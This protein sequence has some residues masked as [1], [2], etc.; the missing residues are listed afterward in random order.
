MGNSEKIVEDKHPEKIKIMM[1]DDDPSFFELLSHNIKELYPASEIQFFEDPVD[2][3]NFY[4]DN[5]HDIDI[6][7]LDM[8]MPKMNGLELSWEIKKINKNERIILMTGYSLETMIAEKGAEAVEFFL[9]KNE[10]DPSLKNFP[11]LLD[12]YVRKI[13]W[14]KESQINYQKSQEELHNKTRLL[15]LLQD[16]IINAD[17]A[18]TVEEAMQ[19]CLDNICSYSGWPVGHLYLSDFEGRLLPTKIWHLDSPEQF[20]TFRTITEN[21][22]FDSGVGLPGQVLAGRKPTWIKDVTKDSNFP[23]AKLAKDINVKAGFAFPISEGK[24]VVAVLEFFSNKIEEPDKHLLET[25]SVFSTQLGRM[26]ERKKAEKELNK[27]ASEM[28]QLAE[29]RSKQLVHADRMATLGTL[30][31][32]I[33]HEVNNPVGFVS[34]NLQIFE[35]LWNKGIKACLEKANREN[36]D[37]NL[38][39]ALDEMPKMVKV[40][41]EGTKRITNIVQ[42]LGKFSRITRPVFETSDICE[43]IET[44]VKFCRLDLFMKHE[45]KI[46]LDLPNNI[47]NIKVSR[48]EMEQVLI[49]IITNSG[50]AMKGIAGGKE[51]ILKIAASHVSNNIIIEINDNG[52][53]MDEKTLDKI[54]NPFFTT[55]DVGKG[56]GLGLSICRGIVEQ[57]RGT[58]TARSTLGEETT[59][60]IILPIDPQKKERRTKDQKIIGGMRDDDK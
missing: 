51:L 60:T 27:Y 30:S 5:Y 4:R 39:F 10:I 57:H 16:V 6:I 44:A 12:F 26:T 40:M 56:T 15:Q 55:K 28:E 24:K 53:G 8:V 34:V 20:K 45:V 35:K 42:S 41:K 54:F 17:E 25:M 36:E 14:I 38:S 31:A 46:K 7:I 3:L 21:T 23:R 48:Q 49:N 13:L 33:A 19:V 37:K 58:I 43:I 29:E 47:P 50:H 9:S 59:F 2:A 22:P 11:I 1:V 32:G 52:S 18:S